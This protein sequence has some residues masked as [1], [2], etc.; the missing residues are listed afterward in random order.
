MSLGAL[1]LAPLSATSAF[2][3]AALSA[4]CE[5]SANS[6][7]SCCDR[8]CALDSCSDSVVREEWASVDLPAMICFKTNHRKYQ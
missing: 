7:S 4:S 1:S 5:D 8:A 3:N 6:F 2:S